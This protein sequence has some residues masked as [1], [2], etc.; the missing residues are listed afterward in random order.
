MASVDEEDCCLCFSQYRCLN[1][2][3]KSLFAWLNSPT[4][5][6]RQPLL[7]KAAAMSLKRLV[8]SDVL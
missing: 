8:A 6:E 4:I 5:S 2:L 3:S 7:L 1:E